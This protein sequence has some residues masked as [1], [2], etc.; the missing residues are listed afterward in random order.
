MPLCA[1]SVSNLFNVD[2]SV[3][4]ILEQVFTRPFLR[5][6]FPGIDGMESSDDED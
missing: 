5:R 1:C 2:Q 6:A 3:D 4:F